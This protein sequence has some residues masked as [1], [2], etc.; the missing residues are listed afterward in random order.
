[1]ARKIGCRGY[2]PKLLLCRTLPEYF[3]FR[4]RG[5]LLGGSLG[6]SEPLFCSYLVAWNRSEPLF[7]EAIGSLGC[8]EPLFLPALRRAFPLGGT[9]SADLMSW[10]FLE[11]VYYA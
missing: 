11:Y 3:G 6:R 2:M 7:S 8:S 5:T 4:A 9:P 1:M 10:R